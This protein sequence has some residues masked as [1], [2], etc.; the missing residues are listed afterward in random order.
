L[1][2]FQ[3]RLPSLLQQAVGSS[4]DGIS[5]DTRTKAL[6]IM[7][8][9]FPWRKPLPVLL[10]INYDVCSPSSFFFNC[11]SKD[12]FKLHIEVKVIFSPLQK[13][14]AFMNIYKTTTVIDKAVP[15]LLRQVF[16]K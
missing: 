6:L 2:P 8:L 13:L 12:Q 16:I 4:I 14:N 15:R 9:M 1:P 10:N 3:A 7:S 5:A 11:L